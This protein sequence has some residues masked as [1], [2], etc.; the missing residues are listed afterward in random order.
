MPANGHLTLELRA[1]DPDYA[2]SE[3]RL[4]GELN[5]QNVLDERLL[6]ETHAG[7]LLSRYEFDPAKLN[8]KV[9]DTIEYWATAKDN[10]TPTPNETQTARRLIRIGSPEA[11]AFAVGST[12]AERLQER[13][14][15]LREQSPR[16]RRRRQQR[17]AEW[18]KPPATEVGRRG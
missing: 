12:G 7:P 11:P 5:R 8:L 13:P 17:P 18:R 15:R 4:S 6:K 2:L 1:L 16:S 9:G 3:V 14:R 10:R